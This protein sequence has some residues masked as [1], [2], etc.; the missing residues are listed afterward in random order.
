MAEGVLRK[1]LAD[2]A[3]AD[4]IE[5]DSVATHPYH[6]GQPP[7]ADAIAAAKKR[8][9]EIQHLIARPV[10][11]H[12]L[13]HFDMVLGMDLANINHLRTIAPTRC[14]PKIELLLA[15]GDRFHGKE[16]PDPYGKKA[17]D[18]ELV[19]DM[20]EDGCSGLVELLARTPIR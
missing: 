1:M 10:K 15:Y 14:K 19:L 9:Y 20:I 8:G 6:Q 12:D 13:D 3:I 4:R 5:I 7:F 16:I 17:R 2:E 11:P 18:Y